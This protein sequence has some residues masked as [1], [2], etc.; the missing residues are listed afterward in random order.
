MPEKISK[1]LINK[2]DGINWDDF[3]LIDKRFDERIQRF[4]KRIYDLEIIQWRLDRV[5]KVLQERF[6]ID[7]NAIN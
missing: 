1:S 4:D 5:E 6:Q 3:A 2:K 7:I